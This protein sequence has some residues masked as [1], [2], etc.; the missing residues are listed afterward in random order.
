MYK[1]DKCDK[2]FKTQQGLNSHNGWH[3][4]SNRK[5]NFI[6]YNKKVKRG[7]LIKENTNQF[8]K[9]KRDGRVIVVSDETRKKISVNSKKQKWDDERRRKHS[10]SM[11]KAVKNNPNSYSANNVS[12]RT[13]LIEYR[14]TRVKGNWEL[15][16]AKWL[17]NNNIKWTNKIDG[18]SYDWNNETHTYFP[19]FY[20]IDLDKYVEVKG[21][22]RERD[23]CKWKV[24]DNLIVIKKKEIKLIKENKFGPISAL[25]HNQLKP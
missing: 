22:E 23:R 1:C 3:D 15:L 24:L 5:S 21:Y 7:T 16:V 8:I 20:L 2:E 4:N 18:I 10:E 25:A 9:A 19:D 14:N 6:Q 13:K 17:D 11:K 12:G